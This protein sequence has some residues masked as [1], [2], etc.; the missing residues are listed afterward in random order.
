MKRITLT[1]WY[2]FGLLLLAMLCE[3]AITYA[4]SGESTGRIIFRVTT[5]LAAVV[6]LIAV[7]F[8]V[9]QKRRPESVLFSKTSTAIAF[10]VA[11]ILTL[12]VIGGILG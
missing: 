4:P 9:Q 6:G 11:A 1:A 5:F 12:V 7:W 2:V 3:S 8:T 10:A